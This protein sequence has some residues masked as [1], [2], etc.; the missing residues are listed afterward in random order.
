MRAE[1]VKVVPDGRNNEGLL[2][3]LSRV[4][5]SLTMQEHTAQ[6]GWCGFHGPGG[7]SCGRQS[8]R[9]ELGSRVVEE[10]KEQAGDGQAKLFGAAL[11]VVVLFLRDP[12][13]D[14]MVLDLG[15]YE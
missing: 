5:R 10:L 2:D 14:A 11:D 9:L 3:P 6:S 1:I 12:E 4:H 15:R 13:A 8:V 7:L